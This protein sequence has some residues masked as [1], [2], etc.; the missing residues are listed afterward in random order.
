M[1]AYT[2]KHLI[3]IPWQS[4]LK[5]VHPF[6]KYCEAMVQVSNDIAFGPNQNSA[7]S[8]HEGLGEEK[9]KSK[10]KE[11]NVQHYKQVLICKP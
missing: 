3:L 5:H 6:L 8:S 10:G 11:R 7:A 4:G 9:I 1:C 2:V